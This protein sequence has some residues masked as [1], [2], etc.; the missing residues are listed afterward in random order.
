MEVDRRAFF[1][2]LGSTAVIAAMPDEEKAEALEHA[3]SQYLSDAV[4]ELRARKV[5]V[6]DASAMLG[7][8]HQRI[9]QIARPKRSKKSRSKRDVG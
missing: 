2:T 4:A 8:S 3:A 6:R 5:S 7:L 9:Q 1:A